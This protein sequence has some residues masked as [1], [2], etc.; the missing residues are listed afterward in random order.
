MA[1][2]KVAKK[3]MASKKV[4]NKKGPKQKLGQG[5]KKTNSMSSKSRPMLAAAVFCT[6]LSKS[7]SGKTNCQDIF[8]SFLAWAY[9][10]AVRSW[11]A[12]LTVY[13]LPPGNTTIVVSI[14]YGRE[15]KT[16]LT[17]ADIKRG[18]ED[19]G[20]IINIPL[21]YKFQNEGRHILHFNVVGTTKVLKIPLNVLTRQWPIFSNKD[22]EFLKNNPSIP[23]SIR[24]NVS[25]S[26]CSRPYT[27]EDN[28]L[29]KVDL[30][31]GVLP[32]PDSGLFECEGCGHKLH[33]K[34]IQGQLRSSI[35][36]AVSTARRGAK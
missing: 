8:T 10:T 20:S 21:H 22:L 13:D 30:V 4:A 9:P 26:N 2:K 33:L 18:P 15:R 29:P 35:K 11:F 19:L 17:N 36:T 31:G 25:C 27:F 5:K 7:E 32:F 14:S 3:K 24:V 23:H 12:I 6:A 28:V 1:R 16:T 34:D